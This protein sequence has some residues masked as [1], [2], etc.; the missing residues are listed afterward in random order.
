VEA[1]EIEAEEAEKGVKAGKEG[2][3]E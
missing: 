1:L 3:H 2:G